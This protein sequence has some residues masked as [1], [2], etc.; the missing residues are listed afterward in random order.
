MLFHVCVPITS[1]HVPPA[2]PV[3][4]SCCPHSGRAKPSP[5]IHPPS[6]LT[7][8]LSPISPS[9][10]SPAPPHPLNDLIQFL[11][12][13]SLP[14]RTKPPEPLPL[15]RHH[16]HEYPDRRSLRHTL[17][18]RIPLEPRPPFSYLADCSP[19]DRQCPSLATSG[20]LGIRCPYHLGHDLFVDALGQ[21]QRRQTTRSQASN[22]L[23]QKQRPQCFAGYSRAHTKGPP[24]Q[25][26]CSSAKPY[27][28]PA[29]LP[30][31]CFESGTLPRFRSEPRRCTWQLQAAQHSWKT[32]HPPLSVST[33]H[34]ELGRNRSQETFLG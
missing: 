15:P 34:T 1:G 23:E 3:P 29:V 30:S 4:S 17:T 16:H 31:S 32:K 12:F 25:T 13:L 10:S 21:P 19:L 18:P 9:L 6:Q 22:H 33:R 2:S 8:F 11:P 14:H 7:L 27:A 28:E 24:R 20:P 26:G 5:S